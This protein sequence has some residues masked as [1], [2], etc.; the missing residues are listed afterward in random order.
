ME[1]Q[2]FFFCKRE[3]CRISSYAGG[4][5]AGSLLIKEGVLQSFLLIWRECCRGSSSVGGG[6]AGF[7]PM[8]S[9]GESV[10]GF[11]LWRRESCGFSCC[12]K[13]SVA[14]FL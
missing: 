3:C 14:G 10:A 1:L 4:R 9:I 2:G 13:V 7:L 12:I 5:V 8:N 11:F 6:V